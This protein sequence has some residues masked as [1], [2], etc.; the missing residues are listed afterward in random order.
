MITMKD[1]SKIYENGKEDYYALNNVSVKIEKGITVILGPSGAGKSTL[2]NILSG[3]EKNDY[4]EV[5]AE[6]ANES[7]Y[8]NTMNDKEL[9]M[10]RRKYVGFVFQQYH[11]LQHL[12]VD[13]NIRMGAYLSR[14]KDYSDIVETLGLKDLLNK[15]P[16]Q[17]SGGQQ[18]RVSI[19][20][21]LAK[22]PEIL[23]CDEPTGALDEKTGKQVLKLL[24]DYQKVNDMTIIMVTHNPG[25]AEMAD[26]I[27]KLVNGQIN[28]DY[29]NTNV[30]APEKVRWA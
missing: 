24:R 22:K 10:F 4:G 15:M 23:F 26:H 18:Q 5:C 1:V 28:M 12:N 8:L 20:R 17:L 30:I 16:Y 11:L 2:L 6:F 29:I 7:L 21:A 13:N 27:I 3:L 25:I 14:M 19:A 9:S